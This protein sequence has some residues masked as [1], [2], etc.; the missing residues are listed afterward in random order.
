MAPEEDK[1]AIKVTVE[2]QKPKDDKKKP[3]KKD[4]TLEE[5]MSEEDL[6]LK[7]RLESCVSTLLNKDEEESVTV[8]IRRN[9]LDMIVKEVRTATSSMTSV[10]KPLKFLRPHF[11]DLK[12]FHKTLVEDGN[13]EKDDQFLVLRALLADVLSVLAMTLGDHGKFF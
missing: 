6:E 4:E 7:E 5:T 12:K 11:D 2:T 8:A 13:V 10:P 9:A 3:S 1:E